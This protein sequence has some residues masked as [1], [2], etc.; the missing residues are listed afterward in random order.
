MRVGGGGGAP[1][2]EKEPTL[3]LKFVLPDDD[4]FKLPTKKHCK[5]YPLLPQ[6]QYKLLKILLARARL[7]V[8]H[9]AEAN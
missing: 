8:F 3:G 2:T 1:P 7:A 5:T 4:Y 6:G 9:I